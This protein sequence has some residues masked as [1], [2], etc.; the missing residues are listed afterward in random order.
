MSFTLPVPTTTN[1]GSGSQGSVTSTSVSPRTKRSR[2][3]N[4]T[5]EETDVIFEVIDTNKISTIRNRKERFRCLE[6]FAA[7]IHKRSQEI[8]ISKHE[9]GEVPLRSAKSLWTRYKNVRF[10]TKS[11]TEPGSASSMTEQDDS[12]TP[13]AALSDQMILNETTA[14]VQEL[15]QCVTQL[16]QADFWDLSS[17][18]K[19]LLII[20]N[21]SINVLNNTHGTI[22]KWWIWKAQ[23]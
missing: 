6:D 12:P 9:N 18:T 5:K 8:L 13:R 1:V 16:I 17:I 3:L 15:F 21:M 2:T 22:R 11:S 7:L 23:K 14:A 4:F 20:Y 19:L 10:L